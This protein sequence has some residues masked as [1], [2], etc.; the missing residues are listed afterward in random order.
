M[1][2][3]Y[4]ILIFTSLWMIG[5]LVSCELNMEGDTA[6]SVSGTDSVTISS[7]AQD[8]KGEVTGILLD[9]TMNTAVL[10]TT[11]KDTLSFTTS[12]A[13]MD[14]PESGIRIGD[15]LVVTYEGNLENR[16]SFP[17][18]TARKVVV[19]SGKHGADF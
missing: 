6:S 16:H 12:D 2:R 14:T 3:K 18:A 15:T 19:R 4:S 17:I 7:G 1:V 13:E 9:A 8:V 11:G 10:V 5:S